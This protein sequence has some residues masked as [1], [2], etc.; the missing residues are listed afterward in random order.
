MGINRFGIFTSTTRTYFSAQA[1]MVIDDFTVNLL[2]TRHADSQRVETV[3][4]IRGDVS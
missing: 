3:R 2:G 1:I 4:N